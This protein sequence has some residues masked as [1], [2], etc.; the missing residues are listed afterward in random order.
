[1][2]KSFRL[3]AKRDPQ[4]DTRSLNRVNQNSAAKNRTSGGLTARVWKG[5]GKSKSLSPYL[6]RAGGRGPSYV[7]MLMWSHYMG[8]KH[9]NLS[10]VPERATMQRVTPLPVSYRFQSV[11]A[12][13]HPTALQSH[14]HC[15]HRLRRTLYLN[16]C[17]S[18]TS[19]ARSDDK[20]KEKRLQLVHLN[21]CL[22]KFMWLRRE[23]SQN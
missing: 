5:N 23:Q 7:C 1:M 4:T 15:V 13:M 16:A 17:W 22:W 3:T 18:P 8:S 11:W 9:A 20:K 19:R 14:P 6:F 12:N 10:A 21:R 2:L